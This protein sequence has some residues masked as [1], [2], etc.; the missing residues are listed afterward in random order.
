MSCDNCG[1]PILCE[2]KCLTIDIQDLD[3]LVYSINKYLCRLSETIKN[4]LQWGHKC[5]GNEHEVFTKLDC[6]KQ[7]LSRYLEKSIRGAKHCLSSEKIQYIIEKV[8]DIIPKESCPS[9]REDIQIDP[10]LENNWI[11]LNPYCVSYDKWNKYAKVVARDLN[12]SLTVEEDICNFALE[13]SKKV[14]PCEILLAA[15][16]FRKADCE[17]G[18]KISRTEEECKLDWKLLIEQ[19]PSCDLDLKSYL[20]LSKE[21]NL[22]F[23]IIKEVYDCNLCLTTQTDEDTNQCVYLKTPLGEYELVEL[24]ATE[25]QLLKN[26]YS[27]KTI[28]NK[29]LADYK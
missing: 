23:D 18:L 3:N 10:S 24:A 26:N 15:E 11:K 14:I 29:Y 13:L 17:L 20:T 9:C 12:L 6:Y 4:E 5:K 22:S 2:D 27:P 8:K 7:A 28:L 25:D 1:C 21:C 16:A 19:V